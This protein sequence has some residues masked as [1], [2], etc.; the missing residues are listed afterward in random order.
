MEYD[1]FSRN[2]YYYDPVEICGD[3]RSR[4][5]IL[6]FWCERTENKNIPLTF[7]AG[8]V[9]V[10]ELGSMFGYLATFV[11]K[12]LKFN[13]T[14]ADKDSREC[15]SNEFVM[16]FATRHW[17]S[18]D[19]LSIQ[20]HEYLLFIYPNFDEC[21]SDGLRKQLTQIFWATFVY[22]ASIQ[23]S[24][25]TEIQVSI[26]MLRSLN[27]GVSFDTRDALISNRNI[28]F[29]C[30]NQSIVFCTQRS[31]VVCEVWMVNNWIRKI[32]QRYF[33]RLPEMC[34]HHSLCICRSLVGV[35]FSYFGKRIIFSQ[36]F[37]SC[38]APFPSMFLVFLNIPLE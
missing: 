31:E 30:V 16:I 38:I 32:C 13:A 25:F 22:L 14:A 37:F 3:Y 5:S 19:L 26:K 20:R 4:L 15:K 17:P 21:I 8:V 28:F 12:K 2:I 27:S 23:P 10:A 11:R 18:T 24:K 35:P 1:G 36:L 7:T 29:V 6:P 34:A 33:L 9:S